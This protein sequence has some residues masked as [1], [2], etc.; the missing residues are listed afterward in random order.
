[1]RVLTLGFLLVSLLATSVSARTWTNSSGTKVEAEFA[2]VEGGQVKLQLARGKV[3]LVTLGAL[4]EEDQQ[5]VKGE[6]AKLEAAKEAEKGP[7][8]RFTQAIAQDPTNA[9]NYV[10]RGMARTSRKD[11]D[12]AIQ[13]FTKAIELNPQDPTAYS[14][15]GLAFQK[16]KELINAQKDFNE[17]IRMD[18][19][20][21]SAYRNRGENLR[22]LALDPKQSVPE[23]D[24]AI[25]K[26]QQYWNYARQGNLKTTP[27]QPLNATKGDVSRPLAL[28]QMAKFDFEFSER[29]E[30]DYGGDWGRH[31]GHGG[32]GP[33]CKCTACAGGPGC[34]HCGGVGCEACGGGSP[35]PGLGVYPPQC[36]KGEKITLVAN[37][38]LLAQGMPG[39]AK[40]G[41][42]RAA[43]NGPK[44][45]V[46]SC[47]FYRD[48][49][50]DGKFN[51]EA[52]QFLA[53]DNDGKDGFTTEVSTDAFPPGPQ[54]YFAVPRGK[55][56]SG[57]GA[58]PEE[59]LAAA[60]ALDKAAQTQKALAETCEAGKA[61]GLSADQSK[62]VSK[63][64]EGVNS[65]AEK[66]AEKLA[67]ATPEIANALK[68]AAKPMKA[69]KNLMNTA[70]SKPGE[71]CKPEAEKACD[72][73]K[74][75]AGKLA[76]AAGKLR[77]AAEAAKASAQQ[78]PGQ[79]PPD[80]A[81]GRPASGKNEILAAAPIG[82]R[83]VGGGG[84]GGDGDDGDDEDEDIV[85]ER[86]TELVEDHNYDEAVIEYDRL[87]QDDPDNVA[88][89]RD[90]ASTQLLRGGYDY[91]IRDY[92]HLLT[93]KQ[94][95]DADLYY[96][97]GCALLAANRLEEALSDFT[98]SISMNETWSLAYNNRG[99]TYAKLGKY[100]LAIADF[101]EGIK[102]EPNN[103]LAYR[104]R[105]MAYKK[106]GELRKAQEDYDYMV[107]LERQT[108]ASGVQ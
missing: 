63:G 80:A 75:A 49:D 3:M 95:P 78:N 5:F 25:E 45:D 64:Q 108:P 100:D 56:G 44:I 68:E 57:A 39:E 77:E 41:D 40:P 85:I 72:K 69:V 27:W 42:K 65:E 55:P 22:Q 23:L 83:G 74:D 15:R 13:D 10:S 66:V 50:G 58:S 28:Q 26:W 87:L 86:A 12:G 59:M 71:A 62:E 106:L 99:V 24:E 84:D 73:A 70:A 51:A 37:P 2:G 82:P 36:M 6:I 96:N 21:A 20:L 29:L 11:Y 18:P 98:K 48:V 9:S 31:G 46:E 79:A 91:A 88:L 8:D 104:N 107:K 14:G 102:L 60:E 47:D 30:R 52:D 54:S 17:A 32:H 38:S 67:Q 103:K 90:R 16:K 81:A 34:P 35:A 97:R 105:A 7:A 1:M 4:S 89:L 19:K 53:A 92:D 101:S 61:Q 76:D 93:V 43:A 33:G 94:E